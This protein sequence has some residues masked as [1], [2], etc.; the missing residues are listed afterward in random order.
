MILVTGSTGQL[1]QLVIEA[2]LETT[3]ASQIV[4]GARSPEKASELATRGVQVREF[5]YKRPETMD[6]ALEG[7]EKVLL[8]SS[9]DFDDRVGQHRRVIEAASRANVKLIAYTSILHADDSPLI[10]AKDHKATE[11]I[12]RGSGL[13][14]VLLR[15]GWYSENYFMDL[16]GMIERGVM[17]GAA[18]DGKVSP[19]SREDFA[20][21]AAAVLSRDGEAGKVYE[22]AGDE[23]LGYAD[24]AAAVARASG[25]QVVYQDLPAQEYRKVLEGAGVPAGFA[26]I[27][28]DSDVGIS[29]GALESKS[30]DLRDLIGRATTPFVE[31]VRAA[32]AR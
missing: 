22:L 21:A 15:N 31:S 1:G 4:A 8:I 3:S 19:A 18:S 2:L 9:N 20:R 28:A 7:V 11:E 27:L 29:H 32:L 12:L 23:A 17:V 25:Q 5:D 16:Q 24:I 10:L 13:P 6:A 14:W 30:S 26:A